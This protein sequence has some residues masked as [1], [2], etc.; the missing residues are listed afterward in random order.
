MIVI[1]IIDIYPVCRA[2]APPLI[3]ADSPTIAIERTLGAV[4]MRIGTDNEC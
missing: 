1:M 2:G 3:P 4:G